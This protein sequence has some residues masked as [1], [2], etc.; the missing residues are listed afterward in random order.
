[1]NGVRLLDAC[2]GQL[3]ISVAQVEVETWLVRLKS[4]AVGQVPL[5]L[6]VAHQKEG[7]YTWLCRGGG[8]RLS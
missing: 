5:A 3:H 6:T 4:G 1:M 7:R 8:Q 2:F